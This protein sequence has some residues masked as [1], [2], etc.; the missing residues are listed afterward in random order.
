MQLLHRAQVALW[1]ITRGTWRV[2]PTHKRP[3]WQGA[4]QKGCVW[5]G[6]DK[7]LQPLSGICQYHRH[8]LWVNSCDFGI[9]VGGQKAKQ[10][11][12]CWPRFQFS[13]RGPARHLHPRKKGRAIIRHSKPDIATRHTIGFSKRVHRHKAPMRRP[14]PTSPM[15]RFCIANIGDAAICFLARKKLWRCRQAPARHDQLYPLI[16]ISDNRGKIIRVNLWHGRKVT[17]KVSHRQRCKKLSHCFLPGCLVVKVAHDIAIYPLRCW[18]GSY[19]LQLG[20][21]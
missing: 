20:I 5:P 9:R 17:Q 13:G 1:K 11:I 10:I 8:R 2:L 6:R 18:Q 21:G 12:G 7:P 19:A 4:L 15:R 3:I 14:K 16:S